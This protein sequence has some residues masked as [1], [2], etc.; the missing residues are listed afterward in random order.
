[1]IISEAVSYFNKD[2][3]G[4]RADNVSHGV[5]GKAQGEDNTDTASCYG[6]GGEERG[7]V[8]IRRR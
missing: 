8:E 2:P 7:G 6:C 1:M 5:S 3:E 4:V